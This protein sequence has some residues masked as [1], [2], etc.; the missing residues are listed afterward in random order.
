MNKKRQATRENKNSK[1]KSNDIE[2]IPEDVFARRVFQ[3]LNLITM[4]E[5]EEELTDFFVAPHA[6][7]HVCQEDEAEESSA[8]EFQDS[9]S[10][11]EE[12]TS[13]KKRK[14]PA[15]A[16]ASSSSNKRV[17]K[18]D[19]MS[20]R[21]HYKSF[22]DC[23]L[24]FLKLPM[25]KDV[26]RETLI[27]LPVEVIPYMLEPLLLA[28]YLTD[29]YN[30]GGLISLLALNGL[31]ILIQ[32]YNFDYPDFYHKLYALLRDETLLRSEHRAHFFRLIALFLSSS[33]L[34]AYLVAAFAKRLAR[35]SL[36]APAGA[37]VFLIPQVYNLICRH[38]ECLQLIHRTG[39]KN[40]AALA[41]EKRQD[42]DCSTEIEKAAKD[43]LV[44]LERDVTYVG[45]EDPYRHEER[46][47]QKSNALASSLWEMVALKQ[48]YAA[49][50][51][52]LAKMFE[53]KLRSKALDVEEY[54]SQS[55]D[56]LLQQQIKRR[57]KQP[58]PLNYT[59]CN[60]LFSSTD[61]FTKVF[62]IKT[63]TP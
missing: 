30:Q 42:L 53:E 32:E 48:H 36:R 31:F 8:E 19:L 62:Q 51:A 38:K 22:G 57:L 61:I 13:L 11:P 9:D 28:D 24:A 12:E 45:G 4:P 16:S 33:H 49:V 35:L 1:S 37:S 56:T 43:S 21:G 52:N 63:S 17:K 14:A 47:P 60:G 58:V 59:P 34:P 25:P 3:L 20:I 10:E 5:E 18:N 27:H 29:S 15:S 55:Y 6:P 2:S 23:W 41:A 44:A 7:K 26:Y 54:V 39:A 50:V 46:D 40:V